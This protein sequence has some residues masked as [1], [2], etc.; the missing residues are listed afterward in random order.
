MAIASPSSN[1]AI[2][3]SYNNIDTSN[4]KAEIVSNLKAKIVSLFNSINV[5]DINITLCRYCKS[6]KDVLIKIDNIFHK[7]KI[8]D[9]YQKYPCTFTITEVEQKRPLIDI[10]FSKFCKYALGISKYSSTTLAL[11]EL[12][13]F[14][15][16]HKAIALGIAFWLRMEQGS[17]NIMLNEAYLEMKNENH[18]WVQ[19][20]YFFLCSIGLRNIW[21]DP[22]KWTNQTI[23]GCIKQRLN[24]MYLQKYH[25]YMYDINNDYKCKVSR[26]CYSQKYECKN[27]LQLVSSSVIR[28]SITKLRID[29]NNTQDCKYR[30]FRYRS[31]ITNE[32]PECHVIETVQHRILYC[33][34]PEILLARNSFLNTY[35]K[36]VTNFGTL[37]EH[38]KINQIL[39]VKPSCANNKYIEMAIE[40][41][42]SFIKGIYNINR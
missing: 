28:S 5:Q 42:C 38:N 36:Y 27:Y 23:K 12:G 25:Q 35:T 3:L 21:H 10:S 30:S 19:N 8:I 29:A 1:C 33:K 16:S 4:L 32:C 41:I 24:D 9:H 20:I 17:E 6:N 11:G 31:T 26:M 2:R 7:M 39:N 34:Q 37:E 22:S 18:E 13:R 40:T 14:P 15:V